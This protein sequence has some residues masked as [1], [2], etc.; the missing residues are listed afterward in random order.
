MVMLPPIKPPSENPLTIYIEMDDV[1]LHTFLCDENFGYMASPASKDPEHEIFLPET[2]QP[3]L[4]YMRDHYDEFLKYLKSARS[5]G[6]ET[7][8]YTTGQP[9]YIDKLLAIIDPDSEVFQHKLYQNACYAFEKED[10]DVNFLVKDI[11][12][13]NNRDIRRSVL[14][15][16][17][18][19]NFLLNPENGYPIVPYNAEYANPSGMDK[20]EYLIA[21]IEDL[22]EL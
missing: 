8:L 3:V 20:D 18:P 19:L 14:I 5:E 7:I 10:E 11:S 22:K 1:F 12:R 17:K 15:D 6:V 21:V 9:F 4:I 13:F 2:R 16:P